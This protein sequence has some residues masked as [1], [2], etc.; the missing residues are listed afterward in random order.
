MG[1]EQ[2]DEGSL[3]D[4]HPR[5]ARLLGADVCILQAAY[6]DEALHGDAIGWRAQVQGKRGRRKGQAQV[7]VFGSWFKL[8]DASKI[9]PI[10]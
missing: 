10:N 6:P 5:F 7:K 9:L 3:G 4:T 8:S 1:S 2:V